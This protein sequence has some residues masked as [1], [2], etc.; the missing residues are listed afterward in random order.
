MINAYIF[1][2]TEPEIKPEDISAKFL[3]NK[4]VKDIVAVYGKYDATLKVSFDN[5]TDLNNFLKEMRKI[6]WIKESKHYIA[7]E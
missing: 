5:L 2:V 6:D 4:N 3:K 7:Q 1:L